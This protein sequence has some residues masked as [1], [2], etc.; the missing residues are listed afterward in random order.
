MHAWIQILKEPLYIAIMNGNIILLFFREARLFEN[1]KGSSYG[2]EM[3][4]WVNE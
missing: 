2:M 4:K 3:G 1:E